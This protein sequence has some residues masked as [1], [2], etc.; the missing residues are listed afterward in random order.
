MR[1]LSVKATSLAILAAACARTPAV[2]LA[3]D[4]VDV[5]PAQSLAA[6]GTTLRLA[7]V[8]HRNDGTTAEVVFAWS[9][10]DESIATVDSQGNVQT[11]AMGEADIAAAF[12]GAVGRAHVQVTPAALV[13]L[14][15]SPDPL[16]LAVGRTGTIAAIATFTDGSS[17]DVTRSVA[18]KVTPSETADVSAGFVLAKRAGEASLE[19]VASDAGGTIATAD[20]LLRV[21]PPAVDSLEIEPSRVTLPRGVTRPLNAIAVLSDATRRDVTDVATWTVDFPSVAEV[22]SGMAP[23]GLA[24]GLSAGTATVSASWSGQGASA[25]VVVTDAFATGLEIAPASAVLL[26]GTTMPLRAA[27][28]FSDGSAGDVTESAR[29]AGTSGILDVSNDAGTR[30]IVSARSPGAAT[31]TAT[32]SGFSA[33]AGV[34]VVSSP[35]ASLSIS[36]A[37]LTLPVGTS[38]R[39]TAVAAWT[40]GTV[41]D[42]TASAQWTSGDPTR[43]AVD[44]VPGEF[45]AIAAGRTTVQASF[46]GT[47]A[48]A[49]VD[50]PASQV[51]AVELSPG[52]L[53]LPLGGTTTFAA[54][55]RFADGTTSDVTAQASWTSADPSVASVSND[56]AGIVAA[57]APGETDVT[58]SLP[59][60]IPPVSASAHV[61]VTAAALRSLALSPPAPVL[62]AGASVAL[63]ALGVYDDGSSLD[64]TQ[65]ATFASDAPAVATVSNADG[66][67]GLVAGTAEGLA[68]VTATL[69]GV[70]AS[71]VVRVVGV[72]PV[73]LSVVPAIVTGAAGDTLTLEAV[74]AFDDG[75]QL[76][77]TQDAS[78]TSDAEAVAVVSNAA[79]ERGTVH[80]RTQGT[81][82]VAA[83]WQGLS[84]QALVTVSDAR[85]LSLSVSPPTLRLAIGT[86]ETLAATGT[87]DDGTFR[88]VTREATWTSAD[89]AIAG[90]SNAAADAGTVRALSQGTTRVTASLSGVSTEVRVEVTRA[91]LRA[92]E[93]APL[94]PTLPAGTSMALRA[95]GTFEDGTT[96]DLTTQAAWRSASPDVAAVTPAADGTELL[97]GLR[98][99]ASEIE[100]TFA[101]VAARTTASITAAL[102]H[103]IEVAPSAASFAAGTTLA[104]TAT[105]RY[106]DATVQDLTRQVS[107]GTSDP[108]VVGFPGA[109]GVAKGYGI[110]RATITAST[111]GTTGSADVSITAALLVGIELSPSAPALAAGTTLALH[112]TGTF[113]D[114]SSQDLTAQAAWTSDAPAIAAVSSAAGSQGL[115]TALAAGAARVSASVSGT[116]GTTA[117]TVTPAV[118]RSIG[119]SPATT[120]LALGT[121]Q[122]LVATGVYSDGTSQDVTA[123]ATWSSSDATVAAVSNAAGSR[124]VVRALA[125]G[126]A[127]IAATMGGIAGAASIT[128]T[129]AVLQSVSITPAQPSL[130][131]GTTLALSATGTY[132]DAT[133][134]DLTGTAIWTSADP[135]VAS[136]SNAA[137]SQGLVKGLA[138]GTCTIS[139]ALGG[140]T[141]STTL[142]VTAAVVRSLSVSPADAS[143]A[144]GL[145]LDFTAVAT[146]TDGT[147][148]DVT[149]QA[150]WSTSAPS[151]ATISNAAGSRGRARG[152]AQGT[153]TIAASLGS[154]IASV[155]L[156]V[157]AAVISSIEI[158]PASPTL[159][160][161]TQTVLRATA[162]FSDGTTGDVTSQATWTSS[163]P[164]VAAVSNA[165]STRGQVTALS[166]GTTSVSALLAGVGGT[167]T[168]T[169]TPATLVSIGVTPSQPVLAKG[170]TAQLSATG[171]YSDGTTQDLTKQAT[172]AADPA[173]ASVSNATG[174]NGFA[175][176]VGEGSTAV[177]ATFGGVTG[178]TTLTVT[179]ATLLSIG[180]TP[181]T[182][183]LARGSSQ[184]LVATGT[185]SDGTVQTLGAQVTWTVADGSVA[186]VSNADP[187]RGSVQALAAGTTTVEAM[188]GN[189]AA[190]A[191]V[192]VTD[193][194]LRSIDLTPASPTVAVNSVLRLAATGTYSDGTT[195]DITARVTWS[196]ATPS[197]A[198]VSNA[199]GVQGL[200]TGVSAGTSVVS[201]TLS[202][203][204]GT[205]TV[206]VTE[207]SL[208]SI[209]LSPAAVSI[210]RGAT[211]QLSAAGVYSDGTT[212]DVTDRA[213]WA[214]SATGIATVSNAAGTRG[215][216]SGAAGGTAQVTATLGTVSAVANVTV[217]EA[218]IVSIQL[219]PDAPSVAVGS[220]TA[221]TAT[222]TYDDATTQDVTTRATWAVNPSQVA[223]VSNASGSQGKVTAL[224][225]G[226]ATLSATLLGVSGTTRIT[227][228]GAVLASM[229]VTLQNASLARGT[230]TQ[231]T[232]TGTYSDGTSQDLTTQVTWSSDAPSVASVSNAAGS[233]GLV[234]ALAEGTSSIRAALG[235]TSGSATL[236]V[237]S[238]SI[239]SIVIAPTATV[240][241]VGGAAA[242][243]AAAVFGDGTS[244]D[245]TTQASWVSS[246]NSVVGVSNAAG[247][248][249]RVTALAP[250]TATIT[251]AFQGISGTANVTVSDA[252]LVSISLQPQ[253]VQLPA[254]ATQAIQ[255]IGAYSDGSVQ[256][257]TERATWASGLPSVASVS[258]ALGSRG[259][260]TA[261]S[262]GMTVVTATIARVVGQTQVQVSPARLLSVAVTPTNP[263]IAPNATVQLA[264]T[265]TYSDGTTQDLTGRA[266]W[267]TSDASVATVGGGAAGQPGRV[268]GVAPGTATVSA[269]V[270][271]T[272]GSTVVAVRAAT[273]QRIDV[274]PANPSV[275][276]GTLVPFMATG[277]YSDGATQ[278]LTQNATWASSDWAVAAIGRDGRA[279][280]YGVGTTTIS[281]SFQGVT[282][283]TTLTVT[284]ARL[285]S[286]VI[287]PASAT[288]AAGTRMRLAAI[289][290]FSDGST[291]DVTGQ[292]GW[293]SA[294]PNVATVA[295]GQNAGRVTAVAAGTTTITARAPAAGV[296]AT[297]QLTVTNATLVSIA[298]TPATVSLAR[299]QTRQLAAI[300]TYS[301]GS[302]QGVTGLA[303][304]TSSSQAIATVSNAGGS[305]GLVTAVG[306]GTAT[307]TATVG[308][309][310]G[311]ATVTVAGPDIVSITVTP[312]TA[313]LPIGQ[314]QQMTAMARYADGTTA[315]VTSQVVWSSGST[316][317]A[318]VS[319]TGLV[320]AMAAG[321]AVVTATAGN[322]SG[323]AT[324]TVVSIALQS[325]VVSPSTATIG[326]GRTQRFTATG[327]YADG[328]S[329]DVTAIAT[330]TSSAN[331][332]ATVS[333]GG[334]A[335]SASA[336]TTTI[337]AA[338]GNV[339]GTAALTVTSATL[340]A[341]AVTPANPTVSLGT[342][343]S[344][345][346]TG[347]YSDGSTQ[348]LTAQVVWAS[349]TLTVATVS[350]AGVATPA[351][352]GT[353]TIS[354][355]LSGITGTTTLTVSPPWVVAI[356]IAPANASVPR[357]T[358]TNFRATVTMS[359]GTSSDATDRVTWSSSNPSVA[360]VSNNRGSKGVSVAL[361][362]GTVTVSAAMGGVTGSTTLTVQGPGNA[363][364]LSIRVTPQN[365]R[366]GIGQTRA[367]TATG[368]YS[369]GS[370]QDVTQAATWSVGNSTV[371]LVSNTAPTIGVATAIGRGQTEVTARVGNVSGTAVLRVR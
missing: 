245:V 288:L 343:V 112:A 135:S 149:T 136:V 354:A 20:A 157:T 202:G 87:Y 52:T 286:L 367:F 106:S 318:T 148:Q 138:P 238:T 60:S 95:V 187:T 35:P 260:V 63:S 324:I 207:A 156:T 11:R 41:Q 265:G 197:V 37:A 16:E 2:D 43:L 110:G 289:G 36:P 124:G 306:A 76:D 101:G 26:V 334:V 96:Q 274:S 66:R 308:G 276:R 99:G 55:A 129:E 171:T 162:T 363:T 146:F 282:G 51:I 297:A 269:T 56:P 1:S 49:T 50:I 328:T 313:S 28:T 364:L 284:N 362:A 170:S 203:V 98:S 292:V 122:G 259:L 165:G 287:Q 4:R 81:A 330:W 23:R 141:G 121:T 32:F 270:D 133:T 302:T 78:W 144:A 42:V 19:A 178:S 102:L 356:T 182:L 235:N 251:A 215:L 233:K 252:T 304:W 291:Q 22:S 352:L 158:S 347:T 177:T 9:S 314:T 248:Q 329:R 217:T 105:G 331:A 236:T 30:G 79:G 140:M 327:T 174:S 145:T 223:S 312:A 151:V 8:A 68:R 45:A 309:V 64:V 298:I 89:S 39:F 115:V 230:T 142:T 359:D 321:T 243:T 92:L 266:V 5:T 169:V 47:S 192:T 172:W 267:R 168:V 195:A 231:A 184:R 114:G 219:A 368:T 44:G 116:T 365:P 339:R 281:A 128:V 350:A 173:I 176:A 85:L 239:V 6:A 357:G 91:A 247:S 325:I 319:A 127:T 342:A 83:T 160:A 25:T 315:D 34:T 117:V 211:V 62:D 237:V 220:E 225:P 226:E 186:S 371:A 336:G 181:A 341:I 3:V 345:V 311:N 67:R 111:G 310:S 86:Q 209:T 278:D 103:N 205:T 218:A 263:T 147:S 46:P 338:I 244:Q 333:A 61:T 191:S 348:T 240:L 88:D 212:Q 90:V 74:A 323:T 7:A 84:A 179:P 246:A 113:T 206:T 299:G 130:A 31:L 305:R 166:P 250:G 316:G 15:L 222:A 180:V 108:S 24:T 204:S 335:T 10:S 280:T 189:V 322:V 190:T 346:A 258:N 14:A 257:V 229:S 293:Q 317:V 152:L 216:V 295:N 296:S 228:T 279:Q 125:R 40:D 57:L 33:D 150:T 283:S 153:T 249:G 71:V 300:G 175:R 194:V 17:D 80:L 58:A 301:D 155:Q 307:I 264:A 262:N 200:V 268:R 109:P 139:A 210:S 12:G 185:Y 18:W 137:G 126:A 355:T 54:I 94:A 326:T 53:R 294:D 38:G 198:A 360:T 272:A 337:A 123:L 72:V 97:T 21:L 277:V 253:N 163:Q 358:V 70:S 196:S 134:R 224:A 255:A 351:G 370:T 107:W 340:R 366:I 159:A 242:L 201:A 361:L 77:V 154:M 285:V 320:T 93:I 188:A 164:S 29:W 69:D 120:Q 193:A 332:V 254:G 290:T 234:S 369:N 119:V 241:A 344:F 271:G 349:S 221:F 275:A 167:T 59:G 118:L 161:G 227:V 261:V 213:T 13:S 208:V 353:T 75:S 27:A 48:I 132:S 199:S 100:A 214:S 104:F 303:T 65:A 273:L 183:T 82:V 256:D 143:L 73:S 131:A 232:A